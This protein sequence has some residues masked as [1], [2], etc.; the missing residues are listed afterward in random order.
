M[1]I[2]A[3]D[4]TFTRNAA[5]GG[6]ID[7]IGDDHVRFGGTTPNYITAIELHRWLQGLADDIEYTGDDQVDIINLNPSLRS[8]DNIIT[9]T[10]AVTITAAA[11]EHIYDGTILQSSD[12]TRWDGIVNFGNSTVLIQLIQNGAV[13]ADDWWNL[14]GG[15]GLNANS[16]AGISHRFLI[17]TVNAGVDID[18]RRIIGTCRTFGNTYSEFKINGSAAGNNVLAISDSTDL[19]NQTI[20]G[21]VAAW[22]T[23]ANVTEGYA[24]LDVN[25]DTIN[26]EYAS[27]W[28]KDIYTINQFY[29]RMKY[30]TR[31]GSA[32]TLYGL[33]GELF[34]GITH[35]VAIASG[36]GTWGA[37]ESL[38][39]TGGTGQLIAVDNTAGASATKLWMQLLTGVA[40]TAAQ[41]ITGG[42]SAATATT[43]G[44]AI[45]RTISV[46]FIGVSTGTALI[47]AYGWGI[48]T[49]DLAATDKVTDL[50]NTVITP[51]NNVTFTVSGLV[52]SEDIVFV[53]PWDGVTT[54]SDGNPEVTYDQFTQS[55]NLNGAAVTSIVVGAAIPTDTPTTGTIRVQ[56]DSGKYRVCNYTSWTG[57]TF[58]I[59]AEDFSTDPSNGSVT[60]KN[61]FISYLDKVATSTAESFAVVYASPRSVVIKV[62]DGGV[63]PIKEFI[64]SGTIGSNGGS[65][66]AIRTVDA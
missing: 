7:Y 12:G 40:P 65:V 17:M 53:A 16:A 66:T 5:G 15:G 64:S 36:T 28:N 49:A 24:L 21:T 60:P 52:V 41:V 20:E 62:R 48:E 9:L 2:V 57:S 25:N 38:S 1:S 3:A 31:D 54:D 23:I 33:N 19:N 46:P 8:T 30:L 32:E 29:E 56:N 37:A 4:W 55:A 22:T 50:S 43:S 11:I 63:S 42:T 14:T 45:E 13:I 51:P 44:S 27:E 61:V 10:A 47:G 35:Q 18:G 59:T 34:R 58:T 39:W 6:V 26:E